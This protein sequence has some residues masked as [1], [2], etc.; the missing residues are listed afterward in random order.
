MFAKIA[1]GRPALDLLGVFK[2]TTGGETPAGGGNAWARIDAPDAG[3]TYPLNSGFPWYNNVIEV[4][5]SDPAI[6]WA[7]GTDI[8][9][10]T[11]GGVRWSIVSGRIDP[12][13]LVGGVAA[14]SWRNLLA[15]HADQHAIAFD[16]ANPRIVF[17][18]NDG[19]IDR[20]T[21]TSTDTWVWRK[22]S[23][24][25]VTMELFRLGLQQSQAS[26]LAGGAQDNGSN[27]SFGNRTW[28]NVG[29]CD[30]SDVAV[31]AVN[32]STFYVN[33]N[34][35]LNVLANP[36]P[37]TPGSGRTRPWTAPAGLAIDSPIVTDPGMQGATLAAGVDPRVP[38]LAAGAPPLL[39]RAS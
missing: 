20:S 28:Y 32:A 23:N 33:C 15:V 13:V 18:G 4:D 25:M 36:V 9:R 30:G 29:G 31:D 14:D 37:G 38:P 11:D 26:I 2:T 16:P 7:G 12:E 3:G 34:G 24:G 39:P 19:G 10:S 1:R 22:I 8:F 5:P 35:T 6:V 27:V 21:D 17:I